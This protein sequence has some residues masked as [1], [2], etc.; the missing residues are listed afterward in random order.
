MGMGREATYDSI[1]SFYKCIDPT[2]T[3]LS[4]KGVPLS[5]N[6]DYY[7][8]EALRPDN[9]IGPLSGLQLANNATSSSAVAVAGGGFAAP[10]AIV[11]DGVR[12]H[13][14]FAFADANLD[15]IS[16]FKTL[17]TNVLGLEDIFGGG[18]FDYNDRVI[19]LNFSSVT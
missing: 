4:S 7:R 1:I 19:S 3:I 11:N 13:T 18:D 16:H 15:G 6:D 17:G 5:P 8:V 12:I 14:Y 2:G 9:L 10:A